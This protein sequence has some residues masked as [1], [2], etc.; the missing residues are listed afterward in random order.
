MTGGTPGAPAL[1]E[2]APGLLTFAEGPAPGAPTLL[3]LPGLGAPG[4]TFS[5]LAPLAA[6]WRVLLWTPPA[7]T[8]PGEGVLAHHLALLQA[9]PLPRRFAVVG[10]SF[11]SLTALRLALAVPERVAALVLVGPVAGVRGLRRLGLRAALGLPLLLEG[12]RL[13]APLVSRLLGGSRLSPEGKAQLT[14]GVR[15]L[16]GRELARRLREVA[17]LAH[18]TELERVSA[19]TLVVQGTRDLLVPGAHAEEV[20]RRIPGARLARLPGGSHVPYLSH[21]PAF[22]EVVEPFLSRLQG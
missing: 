10:S 15:G 11:G 17:T 1:R 21:T 22:L 8:P 3:C 16:G 5:G 14:G 18:R 9:L 2:A 13:G 19:P 7:E 20:A 6:R 4:A 12:G